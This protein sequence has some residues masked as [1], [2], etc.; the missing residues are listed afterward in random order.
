M[1]NLELDGTIES[2]DA[3]L[4]VLEGCYGPEQPSKEGC[5]RSTVGAS[6]LAH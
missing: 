3:Y 1:S 4:R 6:N 2:L 5:F